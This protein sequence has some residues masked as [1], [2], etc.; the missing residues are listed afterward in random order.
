M[1]WP[2]L[3]FHA[4]AQVSDMKSVDCAAEKNREHLHLGIVSPPPRR[5]LRSIHAHKCSG[6]ESSIAGQVA[7]T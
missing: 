1:F 4:K 7:S 5:A 3:V 2:L 6:K